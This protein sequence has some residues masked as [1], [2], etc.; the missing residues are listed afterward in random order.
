MRHTYEVEPE[1][2]TP[3]YFVW[4]V[5]LV[6]FLRSYAAQKESLQLAVFVTP[7]KVPQ[8][9]SW[10]TTIGGSN[11]KPWFYKYKHV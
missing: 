2:L 7:I 1:Y 9:I 4:L 8:A 10:R 3:P 5:R 11:L 6:L